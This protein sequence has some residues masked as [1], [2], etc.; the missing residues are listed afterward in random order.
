MSEKQSIKAARKLVLNLF[1][2]IQASA[3]TTAHLV[4]GILPQNNFP[5]APPSAPGEPTKPGGN[6]KQIT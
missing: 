1:K 2:G 5:D 4:V 6:R 3:Q